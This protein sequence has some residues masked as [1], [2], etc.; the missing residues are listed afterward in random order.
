M[1]TESSV[2]LIILPILYKKKF[3]NTIL[4]DPPPH[5]GS[6]PDTPTIIQS[7]CLIGLTNCFTTKKTQVAVLPSEKKYL[8]P[9]RGKS[10]SASIRDQKSISVLFEAYI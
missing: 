2:H 6:R 4:R 8:R 1:F 9:K 10:K 5:N 3:S 7:S